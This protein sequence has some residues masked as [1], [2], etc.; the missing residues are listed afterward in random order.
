MTILLINVGSY[1]NDDMIKALT[2][3]YGKHGVEELYH[4]LI[5][6]GIEVYEDEEFERELKRKLRQNKY[7][8][9]VTTNF[10]PVIAKV[11]NEVGIIYI[12]WSYDSPINVWECREMD[13]DT[14]YI[15]LFDRMETERFNRKGHGRFFHMPLA[16]DTE[17]WDT[18]LPDSR[19]KGDVS[20]LGKLYRSKIMLIKNGINGDLCNYI[21]KIIEVQRENKKAYIVNDL[22]SQPIIDEMNRQYALSGLT[23]RV[24][25]EQLSYT[26]SEEVTY[27]DRLL[28]LE[29]FGRRFD[30]H[31]YTY[32]IGDREKEILKNVHIHGKLDYHTEMPRMFKSVKININSSIRSAQS[33]VNLRTVDVLGCRGFLLS[34]PQPEIVEYFEDRKELVLFRDLEEAIDLAD[35]YLKHDD[36]R[37]RIAQAGYERVK[38]DFRY[39]DRFREMFKMAGIK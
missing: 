19:Y 39:E 8:C 32:D 4:Y 22:I 10:F 29:M 1:I 21:D 20:L 36:E 13:F 7:D 37:E 17:K 28:L 33:G 38:R 12:A 9:V 18:F 30:M 31:L 27:Y 11:C 5:F 6:G 24:S 16:V 23:G 34:N 14:N 2:N 35:Y 15:F 25:K 3:M 26:I